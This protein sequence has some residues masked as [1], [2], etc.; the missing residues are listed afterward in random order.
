MKVRLTYPNA[1]D[2][3]FL[4][5]SA[6]FMEIVDEWDLAQREHQIIEDCYNKTW[7]NCEKDGIPKF[8]PPAFCLKGGNTSFINGRNRIVLLIRHMERVP[9][10]LANMDGYPITAEKPSA[11]SEEVLS[12][13]AV[14]PIDLNEVFDFPDLPIEDL[15]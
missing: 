1:H 13:I 2:K 7:F 5:N 8:I 10:A 6:A 11:E 15:G 12:F 14:R 9:M 3:H 4:I